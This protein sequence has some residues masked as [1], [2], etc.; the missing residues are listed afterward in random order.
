MIDY[1]WYTKSITNE[2]KQPHFTGT[3]FRSL[4]C[5][6]RLTHCNAMLQ[7]NLRNP[8]S[9]SDSADCPP[10]V[11]ELVGA[12][13]RATS[14]SLRRARSRSAK[15][16][17]GSNKPMQNTLCGL[18]LARSVATKPSKKQ[19]TTLA[20]FTFLSLVCVGYFFMGHLSLNTQISGET[21]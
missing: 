15:A 11:G 18:S 13:R 21:L 20:W 19:L 1:V 2:V 9:N 7:L 6:V 5:Y 16:P 12:F 10:P 8:S 17:F 3:L 4:P 14:G